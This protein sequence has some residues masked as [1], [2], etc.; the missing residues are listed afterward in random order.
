MAHYM[1]HARPHYCSPALLEKIN[2]HE[3]PHV[4]A[5]QQEWGRISAPPYRNICLYYNYDGAKPMTDVTHHCAAPTKR[6]VVMATYHPIDS[7]WCRERL[8]DPTPAGHGYTDASR[9]HDQYAAEALE[10]MEFDLS[11]GGHPAF[12]TSYV[13]CVARCDPLPQC[14]SD[15]GSTTIVYAGFP[16]ASRTACGNGPSSHCKR[17]YLD[18]CCWTSSVIAPTHLYSRQAP[19]IQTRTSC[20]RWASPVIRRPA[21]SSLPSFTCLRKPYSRSWK[22][23]S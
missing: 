20:S 19:N 6:P 7:A 15:R 4:E 5:A 2:R 11:S 3:P 16:T 22:H 18:A 10:T 8:N 23:C 13:A 21:V 1:A 12:S 14:L 17:C 9:W